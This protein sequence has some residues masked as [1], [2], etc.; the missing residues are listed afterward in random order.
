M[1]KLILVLTMCLSTRIFAEQKIV[2]IRLTKNTYEF[3]VS[4]TIVE[5]TINKHLKLGY[6]VVCVTPITRPV[7]YGSSTTHVIVVFEKEH[8]K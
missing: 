7:G 2:R 6:K 5:N 1:K 4:D 8:E 3:T